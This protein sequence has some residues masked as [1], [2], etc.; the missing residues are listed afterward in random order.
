MAFKGPILT[1]YSIILSAL[2]PGS[3]VPYDEIR[4]KDHLSVG[5]CKTFLRERFQQ[6]GR[7]LFANFK[8]GLRDRC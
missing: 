4:G 2:P 5:K 3:R 7:R 8:G 1:S 6:D